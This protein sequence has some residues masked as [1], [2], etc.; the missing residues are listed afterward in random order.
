VIKLCGLDGTEQQK[1][2]KT[3]TFTKVV[4]FFTVLYTAHPQGTYIWRKKIN[5][6][7]TEM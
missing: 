5:Y 7:F 6:K 4:S 2:K 3:A 1:N